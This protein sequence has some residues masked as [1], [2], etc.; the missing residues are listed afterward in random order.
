[1]TRDNDAKQITPQS[2]HE[3]LAMATQHIH[4]PNDDEVDLRRYYRA[5]KR[6]WRLAAAVVAA[7]VCLGAIHTFTRQPIY[8][9]KA[10]LLVSTSR[11]SPLSMV[12]NL[13]SAPAEVQSLLGNK[14][15]ETQVEIL[16]DETLQEEAFLSFSESDR[17]RT[18]G[19]TTKLPEWVIEF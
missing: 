13:V 12:A 15:F 10:K 4:R 2:D 19:A 7:C 5:A 18:F 9:A 3:T 8:E 16:S 1:M 14:S 17:L 6:R 11:P